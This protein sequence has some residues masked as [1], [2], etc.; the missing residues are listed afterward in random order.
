MSLWAALV[1]VSDGFGGEGGALSL[2]SN[3]YQYVSMVSSCF[4]T[5]G[6][7]VPCISGLLALSHFLCGLNYPHLGLLSCSGELH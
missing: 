1:Q 5:K 3:G 6:E 4:V 7:A 2:A